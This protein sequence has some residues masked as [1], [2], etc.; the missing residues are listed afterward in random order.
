MTIG[1]DAVPAISVMGEPPS[2]SCSPAVRSKPSRSQRGRM[3]K[4]AQAGVPRSEVG[5]AD[6]INSSDR[7]VLPINSR[8]LSPRMSSGKPDS[9]DI[10]IELID[11][12]ANAYRPDLDLSSA[13]YRASPSVDADDSRTSVSTGSSSG[14]FEYQSPPEGMSSPPSSCE[15]LDSALSGIPQSSIRAECTPLSIRPQLNDSPDSEMDMS[16]FPRSPT[17]GASSGTSA[18]SEKARLRT[19]DAPDLSGIIT[20]SPQIRRADLASSGRGIYDDTRCPIHVDPLDIIDLTQDSDNDDTDND[21][22]LDELTSVVDDNGQDGPIDEIVSLVETRITETAPTPTRVGDLG[23]LNMVDHGS[24]MK[25][26]LLSNGDT[27]GHVAE[28]QQET[29]CVE[30]PVKR[31]I[32]WTSYGLPLCV[33]VIASRNSQIKYHRLIEVCLVF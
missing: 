4:L 28:E 30:L 29:S 2:P 33:Y 23:M 15:A 11:T 14:F 25:V 12:A 31:Q 3:Q 20:K 32:F 5:Y 13:T 22:D 9:G 8:I 19:S 17:T 27:N 26:E 6:A 18:G 16:V 7:G 24:D 21:S 10:S 1:P